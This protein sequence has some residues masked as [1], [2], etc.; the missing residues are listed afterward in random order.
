V[1]AKTEAF[2]AI[3]RFEAREARRLAGLA[4]A[5]EGGECQIQ[6]SQCLH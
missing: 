4:T 6:A 1:C 2:E 5:K 3:T